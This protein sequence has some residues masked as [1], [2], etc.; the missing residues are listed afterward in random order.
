MIP[1]GVENARRIELITDGAGNVRGKAEI[2]CLRGG[3]G[4][5]SLLW[6]QSNPMENGPKSTKST[7]LE[8]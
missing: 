4:G 3:G 7:K 1:P 2:Q 8:C 5:Y 6:K